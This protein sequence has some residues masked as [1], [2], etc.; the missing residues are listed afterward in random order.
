[1]LDETEMFSFSMIE[2]SHCERDSNVL[3]ELSLVVDT[4]TDETSHGCEDAHLHPGLGNDN[5][6]ESRGIGGNLPAQLGALEK[7]K[8]LATHSHLDHRTSSAG[9]KPNFS[10]QQR[11]LF[12]LG[13]HL[14][15]NSILQLIPER[16]WRI[17]NDNGFGEIATQNI[18]VLHVVPVH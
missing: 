9:G 10:R 1:M 18:Q 3:T 12:H 7:A 13:S 16:L 15:R 6:I 17:V 8:S 2:I 11:F 14:N 4:K 5:E